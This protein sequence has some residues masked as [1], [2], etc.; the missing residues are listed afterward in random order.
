MARTVRLR[1]RDRFDD[2]CTTRDMEWRYKVVRHRGEKSNCVCCR[3]PRRLKGSR[4]D[5]LTINE[6]REE[7][8]FKEAA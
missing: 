6:R 7:E 3:N 2:D 8:A 4:K 1:C 5:R